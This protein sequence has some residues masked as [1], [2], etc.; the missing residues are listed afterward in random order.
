MS[1]KDYYDVLGVDKN[2]D[3]S[4]LKRAYRKKAMKYHP[5]RNDGDKESEKKFQEINEAYEVLSDEEKR[6]MYDQFGHA[7]VNQQAGGP[8][9]QGG[10]GG[11]S[12]FGGFEDIINEMFGGGFSG[13]ASSRNRPQKGKSI[14]VNVTISFKESAFGTKKDIEFY[15]TEECGNCHGTG[16]EPG[17]SKHSCDKCNGAGEIRYKQR[18]LFG[19]SISVKQCD[20]CKGSGEI[21][22][23]SCKT[24]KG[25]G[26]VKKKK[27]INIKI[28]KGIYNGAKI[29]IRG[30]GNLGKNGGP[31]GDVYVVVNV[32]SHEIF[33]RDGDDVF[34]EIPITFTQAALGSE[35]VVP[36]LEGKISFEIKPGTQSG[37][38]YRLK[39]K[40]FPILNGYGKG[41]QYVKV[42][43]EVPKDLNARQKELLEEFEK[44]TEDNNGY[45]KRKSF[46]DKVAD[47][48]N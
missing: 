17:S 32:K 45:S 44:E 12:G 41:N 46:F 42:K 6:K 38:Q 39:N 22:E 26:K 1:K 5:D 24:C 3:A 8:G 48:F 28:P 30:E 36:T 31:R 37:K 20:K 18:S 14:K 23:D 11:A 21:Y 19:E 33:E 35:I 34:C 27:N 16:G 9:G 29:S 25:Y 40:G 10:F 2:A 43:V 7:G 47:L 4:E 13:G 15:R